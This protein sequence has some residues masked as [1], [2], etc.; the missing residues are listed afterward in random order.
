MSVLLHVEST[1]TDRYQTTI[2]EPI[3]IAL[4]LGKR[5]KITYIVQKNG[6][7]LMFRTTEE[8]PILGDFLSFLA[9]DIQENPSHLR[10]LS[11]ELVNR[12]R[13]LVAKVKVD[14]DTPLP[15]EDE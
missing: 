9:K 6:K 15:D 14:L 1:L 7:V 5:D 8:D 11:P 13:K 3:R 4:H 2:P 12:A 10:A